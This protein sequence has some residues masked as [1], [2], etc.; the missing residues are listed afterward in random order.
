MTDEDIDF[1]DLP[2]ATPE[3]LDR[4]VLLPPLNVREPRQEMT[5]KIDRDVAEW[6]QSRSGYE[7]VINILMRRYMQERV[8]KPRISS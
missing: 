1:S 3:M 2:E 7:G 6:F 5:L 8:G 4:G